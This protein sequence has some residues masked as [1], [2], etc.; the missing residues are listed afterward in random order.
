M[1]TKNGFIANLNHY[2][3]SVNRELVIFTMIWSTAG[4]RGSTKYLLLIK[5]VGRGLKLSL[6]TLLWVGDCHMRGFS[7]LQQSPQDGSSRRSLLVANNRTKFFPI[8]SNQ[9]YHLQGSIADHSPMLAAI[10]PWL[11][12]DVCTTVAEIHT[13][14]AHNR[15]QLP[16][17]IRSNGPTIIAIHKIYVTAI[18]LDSG[19]LWWSWVVSVFFGRRWS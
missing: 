13:S 11:S 8:C 19:D 4:L 15:R 10:S 9:L 1:T 16:T 17:I 2:R 14:L 6:I 18:D 5:L 12:Q 7:S 3:V